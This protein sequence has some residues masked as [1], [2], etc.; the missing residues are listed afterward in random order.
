M[1]LRRKRNGTIHM[2]SKNKGADLLP[3]PN[4]PKTLKNYNTIY[5]EEDMYRL[6]EPRCEK[7]TYAYAKTK[8]QISF[9]VTAK[10]ISV[11]V[12]TTQ[13]EQSLYYLNAKFRASCHLLWLYSPVCVGSGRK[14][15]TPVFSQQGSSDLFSL[16]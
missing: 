16:G 1:D 2:Y 3:R 4:S 10:L 14:P 13:I 15:Q 11:F 9:A 8:K 12:F 5:F 7:T 6:S